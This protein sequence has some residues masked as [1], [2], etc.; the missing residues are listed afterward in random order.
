[1]IIIGGFCVIIALVLV[2]KSQL[3]LRQN[4][5]S[6]TAR[7]KPER[8]AILIPARDESRVIRGLLESL[9]AQ[10]LP[11]RM[12]DVYVIVEKPDDS[13]VEIGRSFDC[14]VVVR[15]DLRGRE[16]KGYALDD[17]V[18]EI[19]RRGEQY[20]LYFVFDADNV[21]A[22]DYLEQM[23]K[24]YK[25]GYRMATAYRNT[26]NGNANVIAAVSSLTFSM[27]NVVGNRRRIKYGANVVFSGTGC[28]VD[29]DLVENWQGWPF[30]SLTE[31][32]EMSLYATL[33]G[34]PTYYNEQAAF[35][36]E[37]PLRFGQTVD[38]RT[39]WIR[40]YFDARKEY[41]PQIRQKLRRLKHR[42]AELEKCQ[43]LGSLKRELVGVNALIWLLVGVVCLIIGGIGWLIYLGEGWMI[44][45]LVVDVLVLVYCVLAVVTIMM[46]RREKLDMCISMKV[47]AV[48]F[49]PI[50]LVTYIWCALVAILARKKVTW[51]KIQHGE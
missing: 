20:D 9:N 27:I 28:F 10:S 2:L 4:S 46:L 32:Y 33:K 47:R 13:T 3:A 23:L 5:L 26:K 24:V 40:G 50:F 34:I 31:D 16:R 14:R 49:N 29:G 37:Q 36:D 41:I 30:H 15:D 35:F 38:Q 44:L 45:W 18:Q 39:R 42:P 12:Q 51:K 19:R 48:L 17:A 7:S 11:V 25:Q 1:M 8:I 6:L 22:T 21:L 43:N